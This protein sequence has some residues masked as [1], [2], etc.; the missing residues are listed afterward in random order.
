[1]E[2]TEKTS[3]DSLSQQEYSQYIEQLRWQ[4]LQ[5][6]QAVAQYRLLLKIRQAEHHLYFL[7]KCSQPEITL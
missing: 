7:E 3:G 1:M 4:D 6:E 2:H 5:K